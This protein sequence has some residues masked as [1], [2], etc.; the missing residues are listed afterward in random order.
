VR[1]NRVKRV[2]RD[3]GIAVGTMMLEFDTPGIP[4]IAAAAGAEFAVFDMEHTG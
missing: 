3:G 2:L 1:E 4:R